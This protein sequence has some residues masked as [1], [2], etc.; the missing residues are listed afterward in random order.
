MTTIEAVPEKVDL[1]KKNFEGDNKD[2]SS[3]M[4]TTTDNE[5]GVST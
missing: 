4:R 5:G 3:G 1:D 2:G